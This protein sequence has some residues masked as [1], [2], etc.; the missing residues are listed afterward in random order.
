[1]L[2]SLP[3]PRGS[4]VKILQEGE[5]FSQMHSSG[6]GPGGAGGSLWM[7]ARGDPRPGGAVV[8]GVVGTRWGTAGGAGGAAVPWGGSAGGRR[9]AV[10]WLGH[11]GESRVWKGIGNVEGGRGSGVMAMESFALALLVTQGMGGR[12]RGRGARL[13]E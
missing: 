12:G 3:H 8:L 7:R 6:P 10:A 1:M 2:W 4:P 9:R 13:K 5:G 11:G